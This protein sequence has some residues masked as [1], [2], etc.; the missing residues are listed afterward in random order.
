MWGQWQNV[1]IVPA[2]RVGLA[3]GVFSFVNSLTLCVSADEA[4]CKHTKFLTDHIYD[5]ILKEMER[6][7]D[8]PVPDKEKE[9]KQKK[10]D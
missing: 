2:G 4:V 10:G 8:V 9:L 1:Y 7:K 6:M 3:I 5:N